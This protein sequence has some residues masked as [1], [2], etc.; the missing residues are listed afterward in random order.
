MVGRFGDDVCMLVG[1]WELKSLK[2]QTNERRVRDDEILYFNFEPTQR[3][4]ID[5]NTVLNISQTEN[6]H[7]NELEPCIYF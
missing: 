2:S 7:L 3:D 6:D 5:E 1:M 4:S